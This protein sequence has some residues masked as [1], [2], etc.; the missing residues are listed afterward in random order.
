MIQ[1]K[2]IEAFYQERIRASHP[3]YVSRYEDFDS[4]EFQSDIPPTQSSQQKS[5]GKVDPQGAAERPRPPQPPHLKG[6]SE[7]KSPGSSETRRDSGS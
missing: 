3:G 6:T 4:G 7:G 2:V 5:S 1:R